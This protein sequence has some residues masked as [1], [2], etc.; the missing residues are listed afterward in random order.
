MKETGSVTMYVNDYETSVRDILRSIY[1]PRAETRDA[2]IGAGMSVV[3]L[4]R[5]HELVTENQC[6]SVLEIGMARGT[7]AVVI[8]HALQASGAG[9]LTSVDPFQSTPPPEGY[10]NHGIDNLAKAGFLH[11][12]RLI[13]QPDYLALPMLCGEGERFDFI[14]IDGWHSF[15]YTL[16]DIFYADLLL[17]D[18]GVMV[19]HD[20]TSPPVYEAICFLERNKPYERLSAPLMV[21][22]GPFIGRA[23]RRVRTT[24]AGPSARADA[25]SRMKNWRTLAAYRKLEARQVPQVY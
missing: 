16:L 12:H 2:F 8:C 20:S 5:L 6:R 4:V 3:E 14:L 19:F 11:M 13:E 23:L 9:T 25:R 10:A 17:T 24:L 18:G 7:S 15:D 21:H 1:G 22:I